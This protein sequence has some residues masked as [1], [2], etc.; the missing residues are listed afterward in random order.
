MVHRLPGALV[1]WLPGIGWTDVPINMLS[2]WLGHSRI[3]TTAIDA[4]ATGAEQYS[5]AARMWDGEA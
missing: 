4:N 3:A 5:I 1:A 2:K